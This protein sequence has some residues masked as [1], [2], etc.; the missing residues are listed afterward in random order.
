M[1]VWCQG[2]KSRSRVSLLQVKCLTTGIQGP[3]QNP[4]KLNEIKHPH[5]LVSSNSR[6]FPNHVFFSFK[7]ST[8][9]AAQNFA[10]S[11]F[12]S[13]FCAVHPPPPPPPT[14]AVTQSDLFT[15][16]SR[17]PPPPPKSVLRI[18][19]YD[20]AQQFLVPPRRPLFEI[21]ISLKNVVC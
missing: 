10:S 12:T 1:I 11:I 2:I 20:S 18:E 9:D 19:F 8:P 21:E 14:L 7:I 16:A 4:I 3:E 17:D 13:K 5:L 15:R 6:N